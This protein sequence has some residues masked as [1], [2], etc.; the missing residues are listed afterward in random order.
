APGW[1][2]AMGAELQF[3]AEASN[4]GVL[5]SDG[6]TFRDVVG[7]ELGVVVD[8]EDQGLLGFTHGP[9]AGMKNARAVFAQKATGDAAITQRRE[10]GLG[11]RGRRGI[12]Y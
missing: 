4:L 12:V 5:P 3:S 10:Y 8:P 6:Q 2:T 7:G 1:E 11:H 9:V